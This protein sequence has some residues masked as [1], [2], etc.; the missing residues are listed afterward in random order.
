M[1]PRIKQLCQFIDIMRTKNKIDK[2]IAFLYFF[3][4]CRLLHH[5][6]A[7]CNFH[8]RI[9]LFLIFHISQSAVNFQIGIFTD[10]TS[11]I[12]DKVRHRLFDRLIADIRK[13]GLQFFGIS[14]IHLASHRLHRK[15][16]FPAKA[17]F[18]L[19]CPFFTFFHKI[20]LT[21]R[22]L[23]WRLCVYIHSID[24]F[25]IKHYFLHSGENNSP[26]YI[27]SIFCNNGRKDRH[28]IGDRNCKSHSFHF[29]GCKF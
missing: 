26:L 1:N 27:I 15:R 12:E 11:I 18:F 28:R 19:C 25:V 2:R 24:L 10:C 4:N 14:G 9:F 8:R 20:I 22:L 7:H 23:I 21:Q 3:Y 5:T 17:F 29:L 13:N 6:A 16:Q